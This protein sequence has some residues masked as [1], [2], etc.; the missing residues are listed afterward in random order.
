MDEEYDDREEQTEW[1]E[2]LEDDNAM[3]YREWELEKMRAFNQEFLD[4]I[5]A[6]LR[7]GYNEELLKNIVEL[8]N[9]YVVEL[10][11]IKSA[12]ELAEENKK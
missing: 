10:E 12:I 4:R 1:D 2:W 11:R 7:F 6:I 3:R 9:K 8:M 5:V